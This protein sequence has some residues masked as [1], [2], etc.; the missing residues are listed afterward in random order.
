MCLMN[1]F[2]YLLGQF[3]HSSFGFKIVGS[4]IYSMNIIQQLSGKKHLGTVFLPSISNTQPFTHY[5]F[6]FH[7]FTLH[8]FHFHLIS[9][10]KISLSA[11]IYFHDNTDNEVDQCLSDLILGHVLML[12]SHMKVT[13]AP[14]SA[15]Q[16]I[17]VA[18]LF[19]F[20]CFSWCFNI[21]FELDS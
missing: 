13:M 9:D 15:S 3:Y 11:E 18:F 19:S 7:L 1:I 5:S 16:R 4:K 12:E 2:L 21:T 14:F 20:V 17:S 6:S 8:S 10:K